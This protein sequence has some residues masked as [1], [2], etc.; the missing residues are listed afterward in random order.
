MEMAFPAKPRVFLA[1]SACGSA[2]LGRAEVWFDLTRAKDVPLPSLGKETIAGEEGWRLRC[3]I[4]DQLVCISVWNIVA[5][6]H[7]PSPNR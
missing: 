7:Q 4:H 3:S 2:W 5:E 1:Q 6:T